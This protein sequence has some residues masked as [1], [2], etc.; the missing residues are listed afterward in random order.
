MV[1]IELLRQLACFEQLAPDQLE[2]V[3]RSAEIRSLAKDAFLFRNGDRAE[4]LYILVSGQLVVS[5]DDPRGRRLQLAVMEAGACIGEMG[6]SQSAP[7]CADVFARGD[8]VLLCIHRSQFDSLVREQPAFALSLLADLSRKLQEAN[9][10]L[11]NKVG[12]PVKERLWHMLNC[13]AD[14]GR[15]S[16]AP[17]V[18]QLAAQID[19]TREMTSK[20]LSQL[21]GENRVVKDS[22]QA[23]LIRETVV[24]K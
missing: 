1:S 6:L 5:L 24:P 3:A 11:E 2:S 19:A 12:M 10:R 16:P 20:A 8:C 4:A 15:I 21:I 17:K 23:W 18:T 9:R 22:A 7:R 13:L 14:A